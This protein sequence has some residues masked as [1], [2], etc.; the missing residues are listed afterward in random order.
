MSVEIVSDFPCGSW[1]KLTTRLGQDIEGEVI[2]Y[3]N[4]Q[5]I[6]LLKHKVEEEIE[7]RAC[8][9]HLVN[10]AHISN[11]H[12][13]DEA[14]KSAKMDSFMSC[15]LNTAKLERRRIKHIEEKDNEAYAARLDIDPIGLELFSMIKKQ[16]PDG[17][18]WSGKDIEIQGV[19]ITPA[20]TE[21]NCVLTNEN[22]GNKMALQHIKKLVRRFHEK[23]V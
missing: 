12:S 1:V 2:S 22:T 14:F 9:I 19:K 17:L 21:T 10:V 5:G 18:R 11:V 4:G 8:N 20:Y 23:R 7:T 13:I 16:L 6:L 3:D 15:K